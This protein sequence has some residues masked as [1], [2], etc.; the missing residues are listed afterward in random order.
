MYQFVLMCPNKICKLR[1]LGEKKGAL[2]VPFEFK[3]LVLFFL[4]EHRIYV[5]KN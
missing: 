1:H 3:K 5:A 4:Y 2:P